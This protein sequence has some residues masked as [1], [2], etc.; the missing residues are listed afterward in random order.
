MASWQAMGGAMTEILDTAS[1]AA[2]TRA[3]L[4]RAALAVFARKGFH[5]TKVSDIVAEAGVSQPTFYIYFPSKEGA[6]EA[7]VEEF[8]DALHAATKL[9]LISPGLGP[10][11]LFDDLYRSFTRFLAVLAQDPAL[12]EIGFFQQPYG[13][14]TKTRMIAW[15]VANM[16]QEQQAGILRADIPVAYQARMVIGLLDQMARLIK[17]PAD[18]APLA[19]ICARLFCDALGA[20]PA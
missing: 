9:C 5:D 15:S 16:E 1:R 8:R 10:A 6:F 18:V 2:V 7:L 3:R 11:E 12:T 13:D 20:R 14:E 4:R 19:R 17:S